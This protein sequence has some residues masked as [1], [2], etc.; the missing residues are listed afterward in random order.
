MSGLRN[1]LIVLTVFLV[2]GL[3]GVAMFNAFTQADEPDEIACQPFPNNPKRV[4]L[5]VGAKAA[6]FKLTSAAGHMVELK[7]MLKDKPVLVEF[8]ATWCPH[9]QHSAPILNDLHQ[10]FGDDIQFL[11][12]N[13]GDRPNTPSTS[14][15][16]KHDHHIQYPVLNRP[17]S[18]TMDHYC[19]QGFP[20]FA[21]INKR[22]KVLWAQSGSLKSGLLNDLLAEFGKI[23]V[24]VSAYQAPASPVASHAAH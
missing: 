20:S 6:N 23:G 16:Y 4:F 24:D 5:P 8:F 21:L 22:G 15:Q 7:K 10:T 1:G 18:E 12:V 11:A 9:C 3:T 14:D 13:S 17:S 2:I 19:V